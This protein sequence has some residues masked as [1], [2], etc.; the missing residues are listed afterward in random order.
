MTKKTYSFEH[1]TVWPQHVAL[2]PLQCLRSWVQALCMHGVCMVVKLEER[3][4]NF[5]I[6]G[7]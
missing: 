1:D 2:T 3:I 5:I 4:P 7:S 6:M